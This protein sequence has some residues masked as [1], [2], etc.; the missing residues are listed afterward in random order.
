MA[1]PVTAM[2]ARVGESIGRV[3]EI[4]YVSVPAALPRSSTTGKSSRS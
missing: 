4:G 2:P 1:P 3:D